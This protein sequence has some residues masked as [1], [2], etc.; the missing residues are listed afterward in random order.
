MSGIAIPIRFYQVCLIWN[1]VSSDPE[2]RLLRSTP[3]ASSIC[4]GNTGHF[5]AS[6]SFDGGYNIMVG[7]SFHS[8]GFRSLHVTGAVSSIPDGAAYIP[9]K[10]RSQQRLLQRGTADTTFEI[11]SLDG[12]LLVPWSFCAKQFH[13]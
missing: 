7:G 13:I 1:G 6:R 3:F 12:V 5:G 4:F 9:M 8:S 2:R 11:V 10:L